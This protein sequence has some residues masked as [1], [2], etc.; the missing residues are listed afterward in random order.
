[1]GPTRLRGRSRRSRRR[2]GPACPAVLVASGDLDTGVTPLAAGQSSAR[3]KA[4]IASGWPS[5]CAATRKADTPPTTG[6]PSACA[7]SGRRRVSWSWSVSSVC[8]AG[9]HRR[10]RRRPFHAGHRRA[11]RGQAPGARAARRRGV[12]RVVPPAGRRADHDALDARV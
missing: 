9:G 3:L 12:R 5:C 1:V 7:S 6:C 10:D 11:A 8:Q 4:A 2:S